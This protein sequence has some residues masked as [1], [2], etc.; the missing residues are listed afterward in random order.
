MD[1]PLGNAALVD[2]HKENTDQPFGLLAV[3]VW[4]WGE[5]SVWLFGRYTLCSLLLQKQLVTLIPLCV[6]ALTSCFKR[7]TSSQRGD[8][9]SW[10][11]SMKHINCGLLKK[12]H[13]SLSLFYFYF[14]QRTGMQKINTCLR[15]VWRQCHWLSCV[16]K[17]SNAFKNKPLFSTLYLLLNPGCVTVIVGRM[18]YSGLKEQFLHLLYSFSCCNA[19]VT[20]YTL[21]NST[22]LCFLL[23]HAKMQ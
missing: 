19:H 4:G 16:W 5:S 15:G 6:Y 10:C 14:C 2:V 11:V 3:A 22:T 23:Y 9:W 8:V 20:I 12:V 1:S 18:G 7:F 21:L 17:N 13:L